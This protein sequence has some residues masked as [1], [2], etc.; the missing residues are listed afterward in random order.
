MREKNFPVIE[1]AGPQGVEEMGINM[2]DM[3]GNL[4][5]G[6]TKRR[7]MRVDEAIEYLMQEEEER[8]IDMDQVARAAIERVENSGIIFLD[9]IDKIAGR[10]SGMGLTFRAKACNGTFFRLLKARPSTL[11]TVWC[12]LI[13]FCLLPPVRFTFRNRLT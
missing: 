10:E 3:L 7:K 12:A 1:L 5:Q 4:F 13:T 6:R 9:E 8:L 2:K 11:A